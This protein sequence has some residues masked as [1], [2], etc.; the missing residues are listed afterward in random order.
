MVKQLIFVVAGL[1]E[2]K[3]LILRSIWL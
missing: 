1:I 3:R 2:N